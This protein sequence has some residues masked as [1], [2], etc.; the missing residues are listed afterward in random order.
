MN[1]RQGL[2]AL[3]DGEGITHNEQDIRLGSRDLFCLIQAQDSPR[4]K[5]GL[6]QHQA[7]SLK[8]VQVCP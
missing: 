8:Q 6:L 1:H 2:F 7:A 4:L 3:F 5:S